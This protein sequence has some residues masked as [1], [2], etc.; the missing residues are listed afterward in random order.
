MENN[1]LIFE[2]D[3]KNNNEES[4]G[5]M[6][7]IVGGVGQDNPKAIVDNAVREYVGEN[8]CSQFVDMHLDNPWVRIVVKGINDIDYEV[9]SRN[10]HL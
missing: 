1:V 10:H 3:L 4:V 2:Q 5:K 9:L 6:V 7:I 8:R